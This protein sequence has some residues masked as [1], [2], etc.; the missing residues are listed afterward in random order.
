MI[1]AWEVDRNLKRGKVLVKMTGGF[2]YWARKMDS[3]GF[4]SADGNHGVLKL[5]QNAAFYLS[6]ACREIK[7]CGFISV[8]GN[9]GMLHQV[10]DFPLSVSRE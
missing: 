9:R 10:S 3:R 4:S 7:S 2:I 6:G 1:L 8:D 5:G